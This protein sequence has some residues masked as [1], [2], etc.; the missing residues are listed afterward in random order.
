L[1]HYSFYDITSNFLVVM[2]QG[3]KFQSLK[4]WELHW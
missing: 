2:L 4:T 1:T 3:T